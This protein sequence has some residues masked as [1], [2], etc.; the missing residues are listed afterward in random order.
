MFDK[1]EF[2][3]A[4]RFWMEAHPAATDADARE[5]CQD[6]IPPAVIMQYYWLVD[7]CVE[8]HKWVK[9][10]RTVTDE[11]LELSSEDVDERMVC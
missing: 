3:T 9:N 1:N 4:F 7:Q 5:F 11:D 6:S 10:R 8:W 2:K